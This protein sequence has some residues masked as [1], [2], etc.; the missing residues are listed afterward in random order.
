MGANS[1]DFVWILGYINSGEAPSIDAGAVDDSV[2]D[3]SDAIDVVDAVEDVINDTVDA[4]IL[5]Y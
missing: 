5:C 1:S 2:D 3:A 4:L